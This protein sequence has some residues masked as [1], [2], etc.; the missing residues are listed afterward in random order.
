MRSALA[1]GSGGGDCYT[2]PGH[3]LLGIDGGRGCGVYGEREEVV[4]NR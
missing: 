2:G 1:G 4:A 3:K